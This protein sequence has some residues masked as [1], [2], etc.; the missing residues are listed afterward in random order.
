M[1]SQRS[2]GFKPFATQSGLNPF[3]NKRLF[4]RSAVQVFEKT[5]GKGEIARNEQF[6]LFPQCFL[7]VLR[8]FCNFLLQALSVLVSLN[9]VV[10]ERVNTSLLY[11]ASQLIISLYHYLY[12]L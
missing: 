2:M 5:V 3:P 7:S 12:T 8:S 11:Y 9:F 4:L 1:I 10:W 6:L